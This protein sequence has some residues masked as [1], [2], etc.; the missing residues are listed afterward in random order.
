MKTCNHESTGPETPRATGPRTESMRGGAG[1][2]VLFALALGCGVALGLGL[3]GRTE[4]RVVAGRPE[5]SDSEVFG[6]VESACC[7]GEDSEAQTPVEGFEA[8]L[9]LEDVQLVDQQGNTRSF[10][11]LVRGRPVAIQFIFTTCTGICPSLGASFGRLQEVL[12]ERAV[13]D[14]E[15]I[16]ISV[17]PTVDTPERLRAFGATHGARPGWTLL[18][19]KKQAVDGLLR[20]LEVYTADINDHSPFLLVGDYDRGRWRRVHG[21]TAPERIADLLHEELEARGSVEEPHVYFPETELMTHEGRPVKFYSDL[22]CGK[23]VVVHSFFAECTGS[24]PRMFEVFQR[25]QEEFSDR[26]G[27]ELHLISITVDPEVDSPERLG[28]LAQGLPANPG[29]S[30][31]SGEKAN[32]EEVLGKLGLAVEARENHSNLLLVGNDR[33]GLWKKFN[34]LGNHDEIVAGVRGVLEDPIPASEN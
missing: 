14:V 8:A 16:S 18:T 19:G 25:L 31:L 22:V 23:T 5:L 26:L 30:F 33:T 27:S 9:E 17:D 11:E 4:E 34:G 10:V 7:A 6:P 29:W 3:M 12:D 24:C 2:L 1:S 21:Q 13:P 15:L 28:V 32:L 20:Q